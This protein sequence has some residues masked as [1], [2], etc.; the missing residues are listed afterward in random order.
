MTTDG[1]HPCVFCSKNGAINHP[2]SGKVLLLDLESQPCTNGIAKHAAGRLFSDVATWSPTSCLSILPEMTI[3]LRR[4]LSLA[5][6]VLSKNGAIKIQR[7][8]LP[9]DLDLESQPCTN[10]VANGTAN[11]IIIA[12]GTANGIT[13]QAAGTR[14]AEKA[15]MAS[16]CLSQASCL[17]YRW[18]KRHF[19]LT[20]EVLAS[21]R[22]IVWV[23]STPP[24]VAALFRGLSRFHRHHKAKTALAND[25]QQ[26]H[27]VHVWDFQRNC[28]RKR[29]HTQ[30]AH[31]TKASNNG[32]WSFWISRGF[33]S[34]NWKCTCYHSNARPDRH[35][36]ETS[37]MVKFGHPYHLA[38]FTIVVFGQEAT[39]LWK[40]IYVV[41]DRRQVFVFEDFFDFG[42]RT[43]SPG[44]AVIATVCKGTNK[45]R[46]ARKSGCNPSR[47]TYFAEWRKFWESFFVMKEGERANSTSIFGIYDLELV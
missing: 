9:L 23:S 24:W 21:P 45:R 37:Q 6:R 15:L 16:F 12:N 32:T 38:F 36:K 8:V 35:E 47:R 43:S 20:K 3:K 10:G 14:R 2:F 4:L 27:V 19:S 41:V 25:W 33:S 39:L 40:N 26:I 46:R 31:H 29:R 34:S 30:Q 44:W 11:G 7:K 5:L 18:N 1:Y 22:L 42:R 13:K 17:F 28:K